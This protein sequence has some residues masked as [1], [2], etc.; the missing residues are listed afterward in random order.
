MTP[1]KNKPRKQAGRK[2]S[3]MMPGFTKMSLPQTGQ[4]PSPKESPKHLPFNK[5]TR[6]RKERQLATRNWDKSISRE[7]RVRNL[8]FT[9]CRRYWIKVYTN[10]L[11]NSKCSITWGLGLNR[12]LEPHRGAKT[13]IQREVMISKCQMKVI[14]RTL[15]QRR[16]QLSNC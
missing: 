8:Q 7:K 16:S 4:H 1:H 11:T 2:V 10:L 9:P 13:E 5:K 3:R 6:P 12:V 14:V 15:L